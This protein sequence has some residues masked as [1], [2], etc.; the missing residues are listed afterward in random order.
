MGTEIQTP[1][2]YEDALRKTAGSNEPRAV[3]AARQA[4]VGQGR[5]AF[6][7]LNKVASRLE[8]RLYSG[9]H[10]KAEFNPNSFGGFRKE[11]SQ[12]HTGQGGH[13]PTHDPMNRMF[14]K[15]GQLNAYDK[16]D[17]LQ[18]I[19]YLLRDVARDARGARMFRRA[20][21]GLD[22]NQK[23]LVQAAMHDDE[24]FKLL[25][26][27]L[28]LPIKSLID[29][30][31]WTRKCYRVR[32]INQGELFRIAKDVRATAYVI[33]QDGQGIESKMFGRYVTPDHFKL[34]SFPTVDL[35]EIWEMNYDVLD[36]AQDTARQEIELEEDKRGLALIDQVSTSVNNAV[37]FGTLGIGPLEDIRRQVERHRLMV[38][39]FLISREELGDIIKTMSTQVDPVTERELILAGFVG[40][41]L[42][43]SIIT[44]AG[45]NNEQVIPDGNVY[46]L[47]GPE[48]MG[49]MAIRM[50]LFS[51]AFNQFA[52]YKTV[53]G[54]IFAEMVGFVIANPLSVAKGVKV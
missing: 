2:P 30:E 36:R 10:D 4:G 20:S 15:H 52:L 14:D 7:R 33:G 32:T 12:G 28:L 31:G 37:G 24:G 42:S 9:G 3:Q 17:A 40:N 46:A 54:W 39:K 18:Q 11:S 21:E 27:E 19:A 38:E 25:G 13:R 8:E 48:Y 23:R 26:Q 35:E 43:A 6:P 50:E 5:E 53:K 45:T 1:N 49:E 51:E 47:T 16:K 29:Y 34:A 44:A 22:D 41:L